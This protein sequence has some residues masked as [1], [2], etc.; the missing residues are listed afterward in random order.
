MRMLAGRGCYPVIICLH[1]GGSIIFFRPPFVC[2]SLHPRPHR[3]V[4]PEDRLA[5]F[6]LLHFATLSTSLMKRTAFLKVGSCHGH[7]HVS[8]VMCLYFGLC[9][10]GHAMSV[11][12]SL[13]DFCRVAQSLCRNFDRVMT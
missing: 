1:E 13:I 10:S 7:I 2:F 11:G 3:G 5:Y 4:A 12:L 6:K 8:L 9:G